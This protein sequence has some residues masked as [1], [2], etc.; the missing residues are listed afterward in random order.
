MN[1]TYCVF[2][3]IIILLFSYINSRPHDQIESFTPRLKEFYRPY[4][5]NIRITSVNFYNTI[6]TKLSNFLRK[7][8]LV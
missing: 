4:F 7:T 2:L 8:G 6:R 3:I 1:Y 5:R